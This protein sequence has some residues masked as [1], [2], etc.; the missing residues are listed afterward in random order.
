MWPYKKWKPNLQTCL[1]IVRLL[2][3]ASRREFTAGVR[4]EIVFNFI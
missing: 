1:E 2:L 3:M 4:F